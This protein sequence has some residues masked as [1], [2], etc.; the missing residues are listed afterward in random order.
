MSVRRLTRPVSPTTPDT[1]AGWMTMTGPGDA[2]FSSGSRV[3]PFKRVTADPP[4]CL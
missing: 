1:V 4:P 3:I 2:M